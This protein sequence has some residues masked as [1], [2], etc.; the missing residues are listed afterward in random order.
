MPSLDPKNLSARLRYRAA[1]NPPTT[2][3]V[4]AIANCF[5]GLEFDFRNLWRRI[6]VGII[7]HEADNLVVGVEPGVSPTIAALAGKRLVAVNGVAITAAVTGPQVVG[8][9][10]TQLVPAAFLE[11]T[12]ALA[13]IVTRPGATVPC[14]FQDDDPA[15]GGPVG[16][17]TVVDLTVRAILTEGAIARDAV[18]P[19]E[20]TQSLCSPW[21]NDYREC[22]CYYW[23]ASRPD[24]VNVDTTGVASTGH[25]WLQK[26]RD[27]AVKDYF[28]SNL[29]TYEELFRNW[30]GLLRFV[31]QGN[32]SE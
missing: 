23:A 31:V 15:T 22:G 28:A 27:P 32:D 5:P 3:P 1:G 13:D 2:T 7:L 20:L 24:Y 30:P 17:A 29:I 12:N 19:G 4:S 6:F 9:P 18:Q 16:P 26:D 8:G 21:Q 10:V 25:N 14:T 11:W